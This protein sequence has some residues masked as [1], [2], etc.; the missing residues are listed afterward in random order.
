MKSFLL[1][2]ALVVIGTVAQAQEQPKSLD[3]KVIETYETLIKNLELRIEQLTAK[4][5]SAENP[6]PTS[7]PTTQSME[8]IHPDVGLPVVAKSIFIRR[9][10]GSRG[11]VLERIW[12][13]GK[14]V[15]LSSV[16]FG[17][18][19]QSQGGG[20]GQQSSQSQGRSRGITLQ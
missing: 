11:T 7:W 5:E 17:S 2:I 8:L 15:P 1:T 13:R 6:L 12:D 10:L 4:L 19:Q 14:V 20:S 9:N 18:I 16:T 3:S